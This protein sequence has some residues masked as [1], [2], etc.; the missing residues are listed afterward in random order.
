MWFLAGLGA[1]LIAQL[2]SAA[3]FWSD[4]AAS[5][6]ARPVLVLPELG[7]FMALLAVL[8]AHLGTLRL[9]VTLYAVVIVAMAVLATG[10]NREVAL[11]AALFVVSDALIARN[12]LAGLLRVSAPGF[13]VMATYLAAQG[14]IASG[15]V[16]RSRSGADRPD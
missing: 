4:R 3:V 10:V 12:S 15:V 6:L 16:R 5:V 2:A 9:P 8:W 14:L 7:A 13:W 1:F 11:G